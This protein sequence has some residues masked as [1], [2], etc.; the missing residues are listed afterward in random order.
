MTEDQHISLIEIGNEFWEKFSQL[1][2]DTL[3]KCEQKG[4]DKD[5]ASTYLSDK[6]SFYGRKLSG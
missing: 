2:E 6:T 3:K 4:I 1:C 5:T